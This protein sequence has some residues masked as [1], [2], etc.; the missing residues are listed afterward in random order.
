[1]TAKSS[2]LSYT[3]VNKAGD[4]M[5]G[6]LALSLGT[7]SAANP[8][9]VTG[10]LTGSGRLV[11]L[12]NTDTS[13][14]SL[15]AVSLQ[16]GAGAAATAGVY[17]PTYTGVAAFS[18]RYAID[19]GDSGLAYSAVGASGDHRWHTGASRTLR[20][21]LSSAGVLDVVGA[22]TAASVTP[23]AGRTLSKITVSSA[24]PGALASG[25]LYLRY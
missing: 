25:E 24:A 3:P 11:S 20:M 9:S 2:S 17:A 10:S 18:G 21:S 8:I 7:Y 16:S 12:T 13:V 14:A 15:M 23:G 5:T 6:A 22:I 4:T 19:A 1:M